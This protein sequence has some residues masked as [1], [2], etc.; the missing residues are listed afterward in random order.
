MPTEFPRQTQ[1]TEPNRSGECAV[2][3]A[4]LVFYAIV[5]GVTLMAALCSTQV[6]EAIAQVGLM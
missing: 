6:A 5:L 2:P 1:A 4:W 3:T